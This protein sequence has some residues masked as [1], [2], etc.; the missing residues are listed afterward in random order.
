MIGASA[1]L[2]SPFRTA[3][4]NFLR[5]VIPH[6][7]PIPPAL[8]PGSARVFSVDSDSGP[9]EGAV[10]MRIRSFDWSWNP[11]QRIFD[12]LNCQLASE[13]T[14][15]RLGRGRVNLAALL[16]IFFNHQIPLNNP[17]L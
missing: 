10:A 13:A 2:A 17:G 1:V 6:P 12:K 9:R 11:F 8:P 15:L 16:F 5:S 3:S 14:Q 4:Y 7:L